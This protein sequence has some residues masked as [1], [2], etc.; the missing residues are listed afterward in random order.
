MNI[1]V[2]TYALVAFALTE[3]GADAVA[4]IDDSVLDEPLE[5]EE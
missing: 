2:T 5:E 3:L 4:E 1:T